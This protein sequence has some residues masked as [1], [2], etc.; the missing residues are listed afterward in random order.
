MPEIVAKQLI[1]AYMYKYYRLLYISVN[2]CLADLK[3]T[4]VFLNFANFSPISICSA[5]IILIFEIIAK[6]IQQLSA[7]Y[8]Q[9]YFGSCLQAWRIS[10]HGFLLMDFAVISA[11]SRKFYKNFAA[12]CLNLKYATIAANNDMNLPTIC[13]GMQDGIF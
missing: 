12:V 10:W 3:P 7:N 1:K 5:F 2:K 13:F 9:A 11:I 8:F 6:F 4:A